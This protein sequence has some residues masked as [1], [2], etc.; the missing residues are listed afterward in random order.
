MILMQDDCNRDLSYNQL[1]GLSSG[2]FAGQTN[3]LQL[4]VVV[5]LCSTGVGVKRLPKVLSLR[6]LE[7]NR[8]TQLSSGV[9]EGLTSLLQ[10]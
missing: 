2:L 3:L 7:S 8:L 10:L 5:K 6:Y 4:L 9:F 1:T